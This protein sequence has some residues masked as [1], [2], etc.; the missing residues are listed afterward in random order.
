MQQTRRTVMKGSTGE[1]APLLGTRRGLR[2]VVLAGAA[3]AA[4]LLLAGAQ[5]APREAAPQELLAAGAPSQMLYG[6]H[7]WGGVGSEG[8]GT[9]D[10]DNTVRLCALTTYTYV[11]SRVFVC[12]LALFLSFL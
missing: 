10:W 8:Y 1:Q 3:S 11:L 7:H 6:G 5:I 12:A 9:K 4:A 2:G